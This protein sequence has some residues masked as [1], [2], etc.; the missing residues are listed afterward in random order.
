MATTDTEFLKER[1]ARKQARDAI[2]D[3]SQPKSTNPN[4]ALEDATEDVPDLKEQI[5]QRRLHK[6]AT[7]LDAEDA[8]IEQRKIDKQREADAIQ[9]KQDSQRLVDIVS[10]NTDKAGQLTSQAADRIGS[11]KTT[12]GIALLLVIL[13]LL[14]FIVVRV[15]SVGDTRLKQLWYMLNGRTSLQGKVTLTGATPGAQGASGDFG[16]TS[17]PATNGSSPVV[18]TLGYRGNTSF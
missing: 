13:A 9:E 8:S 10:R 15:N 2:G 6:Q 5:R 11:M 16:T 18:N 12:G 7:Q 17:L 4:D 14:M 3:T 1:L